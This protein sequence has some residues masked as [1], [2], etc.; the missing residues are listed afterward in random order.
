MHALTAN[1]SRQIIFDS[2]AGDNATVASLK[3]LVERMAEVTARHIQWKGGDDTMSAGPTASQSQF[4]TNPK[5]QTSQKLRQQSIKFSTAV[6]AS[7]ASAS[8]RLPQQ[9]LRSQKSSGSIRR[10][11]RYHVPQVNN[12]FSAARAVVVCSRRDAAMQARVLRAE[13]ELKL[14]DACG[15]WPVIE[16]CFSSLQRTHLTCCP[17]FAHSRWRW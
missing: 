9:S 17:R 15:S 1:R 11:S 16:H 10:S 2:H 6:F 5:R 4:V 13:L 8:A 7:A 14:D 12:P 3:E